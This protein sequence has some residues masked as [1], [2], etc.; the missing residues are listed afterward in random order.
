MNAKIDKGSLTLFK[1]IV[2]ISK[3]NMEDYNWAMFAHAMNFFPKIHEFEI[4][5]S[6]TFLHK[7]S[8]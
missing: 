1:Q 8:K 2:N 6:I 7:F 4:V 3:E 5:D